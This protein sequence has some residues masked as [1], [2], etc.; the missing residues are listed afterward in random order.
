MKGYE[1]LKIKILAK[2]INRKEVGLSVGKS[3]KRALIE[4][5]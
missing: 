1:L 4:N 5:K 2:K 3:L